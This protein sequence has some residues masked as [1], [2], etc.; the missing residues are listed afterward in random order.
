MILR[1]YPFV[2]SIAFLAVLNACS[3]APTT[4][5]RGPSATPATSPQAVIDESKGRGRPYGLQTES[6]NRSLK[7][8]MA[9]SDSMVIYQPDV[10]LEILRSLE[11]VSSGQLI[12]MIDSQ[13]YDAAFTGWLQ[14]TLQARKVLVDRS[15]VTTAA[16]KWVRGH[17]DH[18]VTEADFLDLLAQYK[19]MY[20]TPS[21]V[22]VLLPVEGSLASAAKAI[23][24]G[25]MSAYL[26]QPDQSSIRFYASGDT[27]ESA[28][29]AY[30]Q[31]KEDGATQFIGPLHIEST[32]A[33]SIMADSSIPVLLLNQPANN[34]PRVFRLNSLTLS[35]TE[36]AAAIA[37]NALAQDQKQAI[38]IV[39]DSA[40]GLRVETAF[41]ATFE[42]GG[43]HVV[44]TRHFSGTTSDHSAMLT[45]VLKIDE[46][47]QRKADLQFRLNRNLTFEPTRRDDF[48][49]IFM[50]AS[51]AEGR[52]LKPL[53]RF[54]DTGD[55]P[56]YAMNRIFSGKVNRAADQ[57]LNG[58][59]F[60]TAPWQ[61]KNEN[62]S[63]LPFESIRGGALGN[64]Y[65]L[66]LDAWHLLPWLPLL[67]KDPDLSVAGDTGTL[68]LQS[69]GS[70]SRK[71]AW[72]KFSSGKPIPFQW[73]STY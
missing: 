8:A 65:A 24:D 13:L 56:V 44:D 36:D 20:P 67:Q 42:Q 72:A 21:Q 57:D 18:I 68:Q 1:F 50:G 31:A 53:L 16:Q 29:A 37:S 9:L 3:T 34:T 46:S 27:A 66:G 58:V 23:R 47:N 70:V 25:I 51:P 62:T 40:W 39:P 10:A 30:Q 73:P 48:D 12:T 64:L 17:T 41:A 52:A 71:P 63:N 59:M 14:L 55:V 61:L 19:S 4:P 38:I 28:M 32:R 2:L 54:H 45:H 33:L 26:D 22:A 49:F 7:A 6:Y 15:P 5:V 43:G 11:F 69:D 35:Q 60:P